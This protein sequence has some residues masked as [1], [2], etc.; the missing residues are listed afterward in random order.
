MSENKKTWNCFSRP[1]WKEGITPL[2][3]AA[4]HGY[5]DI[6]EILIAAKAD[7][8]AKNDKGET[9][10]KLAKSEGHKNIAKLLRQNGAKE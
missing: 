4:C 1:I 5:K 3:T 8:N 6:A 9:A 7:L 2:Q 10:L